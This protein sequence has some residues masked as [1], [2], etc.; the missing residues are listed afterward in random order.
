[1]PSSTVPAEIGSTDMNIELYICFLYMSHV[2]YVIVLLATSVGPV[3]R[4]IKDNI[5]T[6][7]NQ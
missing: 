5:Y 1:M 2:K 3:K 6:I 7:L 4:Y